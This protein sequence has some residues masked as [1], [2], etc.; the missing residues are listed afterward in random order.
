MD[1]SSNVFC[2][3]HLRSIHHEVIKWKHFLR[4][5]PFVRGI[6]RSRWFPAKRPV[7]QSFDVFFDLCLNKWLSKQPWG[8]WFET[9]SWS[10]RRHGN[11]HKMCSRYQSKMGFENYPTEIIATNPGANESLVIRISLYYLSSI[12][13]L[14]LISVTTHHQKTSLRFRQNGLNV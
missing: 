6:H 4:Y 12:L 2:G 10:L 11:V 5:W 9:P 7:T 1:V 3:I 8:W 13:L 14:T